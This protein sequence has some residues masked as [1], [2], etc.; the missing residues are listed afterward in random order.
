MKRQIER[1]QFYRH[2]KDHWYKVIDIAEHTETGEKVV[3]YYPLY[4]EKQLFVR[5]VE[6]FLE[7]V[8]E[9]KENP[10]GQGYRFMS[11]SE[12]GLREEDMHRE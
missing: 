12:L 10:T 8:P 6:M 9:G 11:I 2:F 1:E 7:S 4:K 5:P 3:V